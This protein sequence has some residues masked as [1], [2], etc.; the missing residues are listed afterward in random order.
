VP[1]ENVKAD[2]LLQKLREGDPPIYAYTLGN[3]LYIN[4]QCV[5]EGEEK[6]IAERIIKIMQDKT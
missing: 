6:I 5:R 1:P 2:N 4:P 3:K